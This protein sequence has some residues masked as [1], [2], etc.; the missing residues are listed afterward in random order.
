MAAKRKYA[1]FGDY[2][3][4]EECSN[5]KCKWQGTTS[6]KNQKPISPFQSELVCPKCGNNEFFGL[7]SPNPSNP[8]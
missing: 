6:E 5:R 1:R 8:K 3:E 7:L 4:K 2:F